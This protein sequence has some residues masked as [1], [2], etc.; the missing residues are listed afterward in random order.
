MCGLAACSN[1]ESEDR[2]WEEQETSQTGVEHMQT[3]VETSDL[4]TVDTL[5]SDVIADPVFGEYGR[6]IFPVD[7]GY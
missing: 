3:E 1:I 4:Y 5:I 2:S 7:T 6:L